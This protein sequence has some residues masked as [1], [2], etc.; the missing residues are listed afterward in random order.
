MEPENGSGQKEIPFENEN[1]ES[2]ISSDSMLNFRGVTAPPIKG[3]QCGTTIVESVN[4]A[5]KRPM[6]L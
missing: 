5:F 6:G 4:S 3:F 2:I 1:V